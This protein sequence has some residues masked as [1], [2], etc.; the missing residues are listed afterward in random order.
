MT[1]NA[2]ARRLLGL[3]HWESKTRKVFFYHDHFAHNDNIP[4]WVP[5]RTR[6]RNFVYGSFE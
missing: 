4:A 1:N 3:P 6:K 2:K 5:L